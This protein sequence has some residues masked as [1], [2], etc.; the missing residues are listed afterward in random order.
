MKI[1]RKDTQIADVWPLSNAYTLEEVNGARIAYVEFA[2]LN[3]IELTVN[4]S[5][6]YEGNAYYIRHREDISKEEVSRG[7]SYRVKLYHEMYRL[8]DVVAFPYEKPDFRKNMSKY[9]GTARQVLEIVVRSMNRVRPEG[10][11]V[12]RGDK[13]SRYAFRDGVLRAAPHHL[14]RQARV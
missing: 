11:D 7:F 14:H 8:H 10:Q 4:D 9:N 13:R 1:K 12:R 2:S 3:P 6:F 5:I